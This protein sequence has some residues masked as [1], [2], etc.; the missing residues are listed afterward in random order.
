MYLARD[1]AWEH[2]KAYTK[3]AYDN[4]TYRNNS[5]MVSNNTIKI[6]KKLSSGDEIL[7]T[8]GW[9]FWFSK[10]KDQYRHV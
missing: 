4:E 1:A 6:T 3:E 5:V 7:I 9:D 8:R 10:L 2:K